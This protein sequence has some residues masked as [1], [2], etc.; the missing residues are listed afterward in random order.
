M[1]VSIK[2]NDVVSLYEPDI[3]PSQLEVYSEAESDMFPMS[4]YVLGSGGEEVFSD[5]DRPLLHIETGGVERERDRVCLR[6]CERERKLEKEERQTELEC[7]LLCAWF[8]IYIGTIIR[9]V[10]VGTVHTMLCVCV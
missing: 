9:Q 10:F 4:V 8:Y 5:S 6:V 7:L 1:P 2:T 3:E